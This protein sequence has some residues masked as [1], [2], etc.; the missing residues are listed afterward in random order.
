MNA[1][2]MS[3]ALEYY[4]RTPDFESHVDDLELSPALWDIFALTEGR[5]SAGDIARDLG[6]DAG[7]ALA[8]LQ[9]LAKHKLVRRHVQRW[10]DYR[11]AKRPMA[12]KPSVAAVPVPEAAVAPVRSA[13]VAAV[14]PAIR[15]PVVEDSPV[16]AS[17]VEPIAAPRTEPE[18]QP[19]AAAKPAAPLA[20]K[21]I[22]FRIAPPT[23]RRPRVA[24]P[25][26]LI[27]VA[28]R[29]AAVAPDSAAPAAVV[30]SASQEKAWPLR[31]IID[32]IL[33]H[34]GG[35][36]SGQLLAY[37]VFLRVPADM[38]D[39]AGLHSLNLVADDFLIR[40]PE[41]YESLCRSLREVAGL[42]PAEILGTDQNS[43]LCA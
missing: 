10:Q 33:R 9:E 7:I 34:G 19:I 35:G 31:P 23:G 15:K 29:R 25:A 16:P 11:G 40:D 37:R 3:A 24:E 4:M 8:G 20:A 42:D 5:V 21:E 14:S 12:A 22:R 28:L 32:A 41:L 43:L 27:R 2:T 18:P 38:L 39:R 17:R 30:A 13:P 26:G 6:L 36:V 1:S